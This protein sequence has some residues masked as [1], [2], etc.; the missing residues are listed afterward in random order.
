MGLLNEIIRRSGFKGTI[1]LNQPDY[2]FSLVESHYQ[3]EGTPKGLKRVY[4]GLDITTN[5]LQGKKISTQ[6]C[7]S[8]R[9]YLGPTSTDSD[10]AFL[11]CHQANINEGSMVIDPFVGTGSLLVPPAHYGAF[12]FGSD[13]DMRVLHGTKVGRLNSK[14]KL[15]D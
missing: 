7:L 12:T 6:Y 13:I 3:Q 1:K 5:R 15:T 9:A 2:A 8:E 11:M 14:A 4:F 10:L